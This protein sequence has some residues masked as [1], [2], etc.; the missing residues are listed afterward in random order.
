MKQFFWH[1]VDTLPRDGSVT[2]L[3]V[4]TSTEVARGMI[5]GFM[6]IPLDSLRERIGELP[7]GKRCMCTATAG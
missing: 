2:L 4:R 3:D 5:D 1:D 7:H 6:H